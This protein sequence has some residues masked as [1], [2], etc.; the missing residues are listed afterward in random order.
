MSEDKS[1]YA[2]SVL[3]QIKK[4]N[5]LILNILPGDYFVL[6]RLPCVPYLS[7]HRLCETIPKP[8]Q[9]SI[10]VL[11][12]VSTILGLKTV[13]RIPGINSCWLTGNL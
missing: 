10:R 11:F 7:I 4:V 6:F 13:V 3:L 2:L 5:V 12:D 8:Y 9:V 1:G